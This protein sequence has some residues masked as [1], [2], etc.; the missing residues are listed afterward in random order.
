MAAVE[1]LCPRSIHLA[2][3][4]VQ[5]GKTDRVVASYL[6]QRR[7]RSLHAE[8]HVAVVQDGLALQCVRIAPPAVR[9]GDAVDLEFVFLAETGGQMHECAVLI[10]TQKNV[11]IAIVDVRESGALPIRFEKGCFRIRTQIA[12]LPV[13]EGVYTLGLYLVTDRF[14]G[15]LLEL[16]DFSVGAAR[17][18]QDFA[19]YHA[20]SRGIVA[21]K[22]ESTIAVHQ[23]EVA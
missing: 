5:D 23:T 9:T 1:A 12:A 8:A 4:V 16:E 21:L 11:R 18:F 2:T 14:T 13:V 20:D 7:A 17:S 6:D 3:G 15:N 19:P 10:Y 22:A